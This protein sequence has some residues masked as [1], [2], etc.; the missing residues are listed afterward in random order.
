MGSPADV[1]DSALL[2]VHASDADTAWIASRGVTK[3][4]AVSVLHTEDNGAS[5]IDQDLGT[6]LLDTNSL[7][8]VGDNIVWVVT[9]ADGIYRTDNARD[10]VRQDSYHGKYSYYLVCIDALDADTAWAAGPAGGGS[11]HTAGIVEHTSDGGKTWVKQL[12]VDIG[13]QAVS[14]TRPFTSYFAEGCTGTGFQ[15]YLCLANPGRGCM[16]ARVTYMCEGGGTRDAGI[17]GA[18]AVPP[19]RATSTR[20]WAPAS[21]SP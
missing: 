13:M 7:T 17:H 1:P 11:G 9:D 8:T 4:P 19:H 3:P 2:D 10:F 15:D 16:A 5:W 12:E 14:F 18:C 6:G 20:W 21:T